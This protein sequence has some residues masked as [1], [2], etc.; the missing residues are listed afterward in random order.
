MYRLIFILSLLLI[1]QTWAWDKSQFDI[2]GVTEDDALRKGTG[3]MLPGWK[4]RKHHSELTLIQGGYFT[5]GT[6]NGISSTTLD[7]LCGITFGHPY[8]MTSYPLLSVDGA[9]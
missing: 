9:W 5:L 2:D 6:N 1:S 3:S 4:L 8:A 7:D